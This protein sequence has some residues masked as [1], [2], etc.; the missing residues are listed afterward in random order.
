MDKLPPIPTPAAQRWREFR[1]HVL[2]WLMFAGVAVSVAFLWRSFVA[3]TGIDS[4]A[5]ANLISM[6]GTVTPSNRVQLGLPVLVSITDDMNVAP[7]ES[8]DSIKRAKP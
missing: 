1:Q 4:A 7:V 2:P 6:H 5:G 3:P 8:V